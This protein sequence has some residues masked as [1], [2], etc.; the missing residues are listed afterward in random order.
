MQ[1]QKS[2]ILL[3][4]TGH[5]RNG[6]I[7]EMDMEMTTSTVIFCMYVCIFYGVN[8]FK[9]IPQ[10]YSRKY[11]PTDLLNYMYAHRLLDF[12]LSGRRWV[13]VGTYIHILMT[14]CMAD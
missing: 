5:V 10:M 13:H 12:G 9:I 8:P 1:D 14:R 11:R 2:S 4:R 7:K 3:M 6:Y